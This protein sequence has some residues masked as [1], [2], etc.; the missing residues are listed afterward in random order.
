MNQLIVS[1]DVCSACG[2][3]YETEPHETG[4]MNAPDPD[5][6]SQQE[7]STRDNETEYWEGA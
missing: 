4:C 3:H 7:R 1:N 6:L 2:T 5:S